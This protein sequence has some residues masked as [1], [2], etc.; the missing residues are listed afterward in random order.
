M[1]GG[2]VIHIAIKDEIGKAFVISRSGLYTRKMHQLFTAGMKEISWTFFLVIIEHCRK[3]SDVRWK[4]PAVFCS[5][6]QI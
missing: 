1:P 2:D 5:L 6:L 3:E 4:Q